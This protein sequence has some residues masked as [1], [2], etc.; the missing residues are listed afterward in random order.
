MQWLVGHGVP[1]NASD[2]AGATPLHW[3]V[4]YGREAAAEWLM[5]RGARRDARDH[6][7]RTPRFWAA[8]TDLPVSDVRL[9]RL[10]CALV[11]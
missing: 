3:A 1:L 2:D 10:A 5:N 11:P 7:G 6:F 9:R 4:G 8:H